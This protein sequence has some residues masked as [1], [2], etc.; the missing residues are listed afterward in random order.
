MTTI[1]SGLV[2]LFLP[3]IT[4]WLFES[5]G[6]PWSSTS[7]LIVSVPLWNTNVS[8]PLPPSNVIWAAEVL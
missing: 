3:S 1:A 5:Q 8:L 7:A 2:V 6:F 4:I